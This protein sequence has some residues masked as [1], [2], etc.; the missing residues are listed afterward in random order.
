MLDTFSPVYVRRSV[1]LYFLPADPLYFACHISTIKVGRYACRLINDLLRNYL[2]TIM[3]DENI[4][5]S[6][7]VF[8]LQRR[9]HKGSAQKNE[10]NT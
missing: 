9:W 6:A 8:L 1:A 4:N 3:S 5:M 10:E 2:E 7:A